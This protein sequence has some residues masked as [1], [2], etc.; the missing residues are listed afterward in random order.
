MGEADL[1]MKA[2]LASR[3]KIFVFL[4][5]VMNIVIILGSIMYLIEGQAAGFTSIPRSI[6]WAIVTLTT[7]G[8]GDISPMTNLGQSVAALIMIIGYGLIAVP[9][10]FVASEVNFISKEQDKIDCIV[11]GDKN[12]NDNYKFCSSCGSSL[13]NQK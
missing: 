11:C 13:T 3:R 7:V 5:S 9:A 12:Q 1:L 2:M 4:F 6:Y 10:G 8:Y